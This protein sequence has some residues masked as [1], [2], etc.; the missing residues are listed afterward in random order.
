MKAPTY[1]PSPATARV[2]RRILVLL[3]VSGCA[4]VTALLG[5]P[6]ARKRYLLWRLDHPQALV[7]VGAL[8]VLARLAVQDSSLL[9]EVE[10]R[11]VAGIQDGSGGAEA[12]ARIGAWAAQDIP[13]FAERLAARLDRAPDLQFQQLAKLLRAAGHWP[14]V[15]SSRQR[16]RWAALQ[17]AAEPS[18]QRAAAVRE[19][20]QLG[21]SCADQVAAIVQ[22]NLDHPSEAVR[23][24]AVQATAVCPRTIA[25][26]LLR[27]ARGDPDTEIGRQITLRL[28][29]LDEPA[30]SRRAPDAATLPA[31]LD[32]GDP[33]TRLSAL[34]DV[35][36][37][38][39][40]ALDASW[41]PRVR[42]VLQESLPAGNH[43]L[44]AAALQA[45]AHLGDDAY[46]PVMLDV[47]AGFP[48]A[49]QLR[50]AAAGAA[51]SLDP[52]AGGEALINL[53]AQDRDS[54]RDLAAV[55]V[56]RIAEPQVLQRLASE[57][58][59]TRGEIRGSA[60]WALALGNHGDLP[61][62]GR[63]LRDVLEA[64]TSLRAAN[65]EAEPDW[66]PR[67]Y[68]L[69]ARLVLGDT[70]VRDL[71]TPFEINTHFSRIAWYTTLLHHGDS[72]PMDLI[73]DPGDPAG[74]QADAL[75]FTSRYG[76]VLRRYFPE[77]PPLGPWVDP[78]RR[79]SQR[80]RLQVW[81]SIYR[82]HLIFDPQR[83]EYRIGNP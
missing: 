53:F 2:Q 79:R 75:L 32:A 23:L 51:A 72:S 4:A 66:K 14:A 40:A 10:R 30:A 68:Y 9:D 27:Q 37:L 50:L 43:R 71:L 5:Y 55:A 38:D 33:D 60:A 34:L 29:L 62:R 63:T 35:A 48:E 80:T 82:W 64:R 20:E 44:T 46:L 65:R 6:H 19:L 25:Q 73:L 69:C 58:F 59:A 17:C 13:T 47:A 18:T 1:H 67:G 83:R 12:C 45:L 49:P 11:I 81:W 39:P 16:C 52:I 15:A 41:R 8:N 28:E 42:A 77:C 57:L 3:L 76:E 78:P 7:R 21:P 54:V 61:V 70:A 36:Q 24:A 26:R 56:C 74:V 31:R 22:Q